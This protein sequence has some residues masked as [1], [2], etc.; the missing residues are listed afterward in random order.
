MTDEG[1]QGRLAVLT[2]GGDAPGMNAAIRAVV[3]TAL[4]RGVEVIAVTEGYRGLVIA[5]TSPDGQLVEA[6]E[7]SGHPWFVGVQFHPEFKSRP[8]RPH[9]LFLA[10]VE[11]AL[12]KQQGET[13]RN[14]PRE[15]IV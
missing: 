3:R 8:I 6:I 14:E 12:I 4:E 9:P 2:S 5:G 13:A 7:L 1:P 11:A 10:F 15:V